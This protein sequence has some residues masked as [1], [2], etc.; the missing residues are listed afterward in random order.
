MKHNLDWHW[1]LPN[2]LAQGAYPSPPMAAFGPFDTV[3]FCAEERQPKL[4]PPTGKHA[5]Y[6]PL[7]DD[8]YRPVTGRMAQEVAE[9]ARFVA[10]EI[11]KGRRVLV[12]CQMGANR[13]GLVTAHAVM[14]LTGMSGADTVKLI[15]A[16]RK[17]R[18]GDVP[19]F[20]PMFEQHV[21]ARR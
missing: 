14:N 13:S 9:A 4:Y 11:E 3:V 17:L 7:D 6:V 8:C 19:L 12:T 18:S 5:L 21:L 16:R 2:K 20:N 1:I 10:K 15:R